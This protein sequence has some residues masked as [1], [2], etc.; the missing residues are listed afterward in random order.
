VFRA[1]CD[2]ITAGVPRLTALIR[3]NHD[4]PGPVVGEWGIAELAAH[5]SH[6]MRVDTNALTGGPMPDIGAPLSRRAV[7]AMTA[8]LLADDPE[9]DVRVLADRIDRLGAEFVQL[10][11]TDTVGWLAGMSLPSS[12][13][14]CHL[15]EELLLHGFDIAKAVGTP[16]EI[17][18][19]HAALVITG[20]VI[21]ILTAEP[22]TFVKAEKARGF[23]ARIQIRLRGFETI[24]FI[25][26]DGA[27]TVE[28]ASGAR[29]DVHLSARPDQLLLVMMN[30]IPQWRP[31]LTGKVSLWGRRPDHLMKMMSV[32]AGP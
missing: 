18:P 20:A 25:F 31:F 19:A 28:P 5:I 3:A 30:R 12:A 8:S 9:R 16:W 10:A 21:P 15:L 26:T 7:A 17:D 2:A 4:F 24:V 23:N 29:A 27:L 13:V 6:V 14:P 22:R 11:P 32:V 1:G